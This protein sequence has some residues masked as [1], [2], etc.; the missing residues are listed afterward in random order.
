M[1]EIDSSIN[2]IGFLDN[3]NDVNISASL[4]LNV[5]GYDINLDFN[6]PSG[7]NENSGEIP[8]KKKK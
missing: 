3:E 6:Y 4:K 5:K 7:K 2:A 1:K 8:E